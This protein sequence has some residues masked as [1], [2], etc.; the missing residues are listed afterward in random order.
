MSAMNGRIEDLQQAR[1]SAA[2]RAELPPTPAV[3][4]VERDGAEESAGSAVQQL[5]Y[6]ALRGQG[7]EC[8]P[9][10]SARH[11][12]VA[13]IVSDE[14][15]QPFAIC[16]SIPARIPKIMIASEA[17]AWGATRW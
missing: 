15:S 16:A 9:A 7:I 1:D 3:C 4:I 5:D 11:N 12:V 6:T 2:A 8:A 17:R 10:P 14:I 13:A